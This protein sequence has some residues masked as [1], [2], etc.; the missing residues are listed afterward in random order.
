MAVPPRA[1]QP[2]LPGRPD[3]D[4]VRTRVWQLPVRV[5]H[6]LMVAA[7]AVLAA[8]GLFI[9]HP[10]LPPAGWNAFLMAWV[11]FAHIMAGFV[12]IA[13]LIVRCYWFF[14]GNLW[15]RWTA[16]VPLRPDQW[17]GIGS[18][19]EYYSFLRFTPVHRTGHNAL[20]ALS[21]LAIYL[22]LL[23]E[24]LSGLALLVRVVN[25]PGLNELL[26][27]LPTLVPMEYVRVAHFFLT[28]VFLA[29]AVFHV[30]LSILVGIEEQNGLMDSIFSGFKFVP[31]RE[32]RAEVARVEGRKTYEK[33]PIP[34]PERPPGKAPARGPAPG[35]VILYQNP[36]SYTGSLVA[37]IGL[38]LFLVLFLYHV[39]GGGAEWNPYGDLVVFIGAPAVVLAGVA[40]ILLGMYVEWLQWRYRRPLSFPRYPLWDLNVARDRK[41]LL[42]FTLGGVVLLGLSLYAG[43]NTYSY[44]DATMFCAR[45]CHAMI[46]ERTTHPLGPHANVEC[47]ECH[48]GAG[49]TGWFNAKLRGLEEAVLAGE[50]RVPAPHPHAA[51]LFASGSGRM[52]ALSL[53][54]DLL[55]RLAATRDPLHVERA[56]QPMGDRPH[57]ARRQ[58]PFGR[59]APARHPLARRRQ[60]RVR[61][62][63]P[64]APGNPVGTRHRPGNRRRDCLHLGRGAEVAARCGQRHDVQSARDGLHRLP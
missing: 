9:H 25:S 45:T 24:V 52:R 13:A 60:G 19:V 10:Y 34:L 37:G 50:Q 5:A 29:F 51:A 54:A 8:T 23:V 1:S 62:G 44:T 42:F 58:R 16:Y 15:A 49:A 35:P 47:A 14:Q 27:W 46:P 28:F 6:W 30:Y 56:E 18:M 17:A 43:I 61:R 22:L 64:A 63:E 36:L 39:V 20:A 59:G 53:A 31:I 32:L 57:G 4:L 12:L 2:V 41:A 55:R 33:K 3:T 38:V 26:G 7:I 21:Y 11:R 40:L 48:I